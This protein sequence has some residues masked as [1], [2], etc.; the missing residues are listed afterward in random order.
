MRKLLIFLCLCFVCVFALPSCSF[1]T[2]SIVSVDT[3]S[4]KNFYIEKKDSFNLK[5]F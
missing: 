5:P 1:K 3:V 4:A 2:H